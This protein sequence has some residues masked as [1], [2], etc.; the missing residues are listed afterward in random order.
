MENNDLNYISKQDCIKRGL[1]RLKTGGYYKLC[2]LEKY[3]R[4]GLLDGTMYDVSELLL[5]GAYLHKDFIDGKIG[6]VSTVNLEQE[7]VDGGLLDGYT[8]KVIDARDKYNKAIRMLPKEFLSV[9]TTVCCLDKE[10][11]TLGGKWKKQQLK[12][13][14]IEMLKFGLCRLARY[15][16][17]INRY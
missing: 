2:T 16:R 15:Y 5:A 1:I 17:R 11:T 4:K 8:E 6:K 13:H 7:K 3:A 10:I 9:V 12:Y 14:A